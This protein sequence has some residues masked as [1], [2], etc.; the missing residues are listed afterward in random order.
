M[1]VFSLLVQDQEMASIY[2]RALSK[3]PLDN[4]ESVRFSSF[5]HVYFAWSE[6]MY[7][8][9][10]AKLGFAEYTGKGSKKLLREEYAYWG[11]LLKTDVGKHWWKKEAVH[12]FSADF[13]KA[14]KEIKSQ[15]AN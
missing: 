13:I 10:K 2:C 6:D 4:V 14:I 11:P 5:L 12:L 3:E 9:A 8:Q 1:Q 15:P 7:C